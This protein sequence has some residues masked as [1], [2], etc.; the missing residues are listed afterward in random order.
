LYIRQLY[1]KIGF[2]EGFSVLLIN[3]PDD[4]ISLL[5]EIPFV[6]KFQD[7]TAP[8]DLIHIFT[9]QSNYLEKTLVQY[10]SQIVQNG[11]IWVSW[12]KKSSK[13][14][15]EVNEDLIRDT[16][17]ALGLVDVKVVSINQ[18]WSAL[19]LVIPLKFR[20]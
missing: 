18:D 15:E 6:I 9:N 16:A 1:Q 7:S 14:Q 5:G 19:K 8:Y 3:E 10:K 2:K 11:M 12:H 13:K 20:S 17:L 4:Y